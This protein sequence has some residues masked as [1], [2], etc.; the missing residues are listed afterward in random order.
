MAEGDRTALHVHVRGIRPS[1]RVTA[2]ACTK[3]LRSTREG[4]RC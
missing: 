3:T 2:T 4:R 1:S